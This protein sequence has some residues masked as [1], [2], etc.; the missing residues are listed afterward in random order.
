MKQFYSM[1]ILVVAFV[2]I[3]FTAGC[4]T[5][6][7]VLNNQTGTPA[8]TP[9]SPTLDKSVP[10]YQVTIPQPEGVHPDYVRMKS[11]IFNQGEIIE[12]SVVNGGNETLGCWRTIPRQIYLYR[13]VGVWESLTKPVGIHTDYGYYLQPGESTPIERLSTADLT[14]GHYKIVTECGVSREFEI[15]AAPKI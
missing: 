14:P 12:F 10:F 1:F 3:L 11:D 8:Q 2:C 7:P 13:Q 4:T 15:R 5:T 9:V 6:V